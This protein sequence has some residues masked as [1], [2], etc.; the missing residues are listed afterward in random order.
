MGRGWH[1]LRVVHQESLVL[2]AVYF[3]RLVASCVL[4]Y[5][6]LLQQPLSALL[7]TRWFTINTIT[8]NIN[9]VHIAWVSRVWNQWVRRHTMR[10][11]RRVSCNCHLVIRLILVHYHRLRVPSLLEGNLVTVILWLWPT[12]YRCVI[13]GLILWS[14]IYATHT[15]FIFII[16]TFTL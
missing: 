9:S 5:L 10:H 1:N 14:W 16:I 3:A 7:L 13:Q 6:V 12:L 8:I 11:R 4:V 15:Y 2:V